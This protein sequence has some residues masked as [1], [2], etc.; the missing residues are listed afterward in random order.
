MVENKNVIIVMGVSGSGKSTL[1]KALS[2]KLGYQFIEGDEFHS[3][4][5]INKMKNGIPLNDKERLPW[6]RDLSKML[7][8]FKSSGSVLACSAL[9]ES[10]RKILSK[11][12]PANKL[13]WIYLKCSIKVLEKRINRRD[14][15]MPAS[16]LKSQINNLEEP[17]DAIYIKDSLTTK[18]QIEEII[19][20]IYG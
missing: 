7:L 16:L 6:L 20:K 14:H 15:F 12:I 9:R 4:S 18:E 10:Y 2:K 1:A 5:N 13:I 3:K 17:K 19:K 11:N 8:K